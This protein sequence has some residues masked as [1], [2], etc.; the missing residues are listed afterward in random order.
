VTGGSIGIGGNEVSKESAQWTDIPNDGSLEFFARETGLDPTALRVEADALVLPQ[1]RFFH[2][3][4]GDYNLLPASTKEVLVALQDGV[5]V[6]LYSD[7]RRRRELILKSADIILPILLFLGTAALNVGLNLLSDWIYDRWTKPEANQEPPTIR[8]E[9]ASVTQQGMIARWRRVRGPAPEIARLL[10]EE[11]RLLQT[12]TPVEARE[13]HLQQETQDS[14]EQPRDSYC[15]N[16]AEAALA[17]AHELIREAE[18]LLKDEETAIAERLF[19]RSLSKI[20]EA[21]L[22]EPEVSSHRKYLHVVGR[23]VHDTFECQLEF[24]D[25]MYWVTCPVMLSHTRGGFSVGGSSKTI[26]SI[27]GEDVLTCPHVKRR[28]YDQVVARRISGVCNICGAEDE[29]G[30]EEG[31]AYDGVQ[32]YGIVTEIDVDHV[33]F[34]P[35]PANPLCAVY[36]YSVSKSDLEEM[37]SEGERH[38]IVYGETPIYCHHCSVCD[39]A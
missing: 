26:C 28:T 20:R 34:V 21:V 5:Q 4:S 37:I 7:G 3:T 19:R 8:A 22:W 13:K 1:N 35:N 27:C 24:R 18:R 36:S 31:H 15:A 32:A 39:G 9:Y 38:Q 12:G 30:H 16:Q 25:G 10:A 17:V 29:C 2:E 33:A 23:R 14:K 11:A 6:E